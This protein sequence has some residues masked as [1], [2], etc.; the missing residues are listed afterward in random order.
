MH[1]YVALHRDQISLHI[2]LLLLCHRPISPTKNQ[3]SNERRCSGPLFFQLLLRSMAETPDLMTVYVPSCSWL[4]NDSASSSIPNY[5][6][7]TYLSERS[8][9]YL[10]VDQKCAGLFSVFLYCLIL[11]F[12]LWGWVGGVLSHVWG[13]VWV[14]FLVWAV[15]WVLLWVGER[16]LAPMHYVGVCWLGWDEDGRVHDGLR[17]KLVNDAYMRSLR[18]CRFSLG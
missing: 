12:S 1:A 13:L 5:K 3:N 17:K 9:P 8:P 2:A 4:H 15:F 7:P 18:C 14:G 11:F 6:V 16:F 10:T